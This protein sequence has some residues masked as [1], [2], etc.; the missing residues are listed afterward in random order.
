MNTCRFCKLANFEHSEA[1]M[2]YGVRHYAHMS[3][4][5]NKFGAEFLKMIPAHQIGLIPYKLVDQ[6]QLRPIL[7]SMGVIEAAK[8][9][10][11]DIIDGYKVSHVAKPSKP[12]KKEL[13][14]VLTPLRKTAA[15]WAVETLMYGRKS[16][17]PEPLTWRGLTIMVEVG[18]RMQVV[19]NVPAPYCACHFYWTAKRDGKEL[20][21][22][23][24]SVG[25]VDDVFRRIAR[26]DL[27]IA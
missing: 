25:F 16:L 22:G 24:T 23:D 14:A 20:A 21:W 13:M 2:K 1:L 4:G 17:G 12:T 15:N 26:G 18:K 5:L 8:S 11:A 7:E 6:Y 19:C 27:Q 10:P 9:T 3:C